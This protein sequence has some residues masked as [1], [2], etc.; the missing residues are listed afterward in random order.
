MSAY[1]VEVREFAANVADYL[2]RAED[3]GESFTLTRA[4]EPVAVLAPVWR[5]VRMED[6]RGGGVRGRRPRRAR[7]DQRRAPSR[8]VVPVSVRESAPATHPCGDDA[9]AALIRWPLC[10]WSFR[11]NCAAM[12]GGSRGRA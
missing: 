1:R 6:R 9:Q 4:G 3:A 10:R 2:R 7:R 12:D 8:P 11:S 5:G